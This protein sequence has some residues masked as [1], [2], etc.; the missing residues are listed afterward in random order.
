MVFVSIP[1]VYKNRP[2]TPLGGSK[3]FGTVP[4]PN[5]GIEPLSKPGTVTSPNPGIALLPNESV[6]PSVGDWF[7]GGSIDP[8]QIFLFYSLHKKMVVER[9]RSDKQP[10]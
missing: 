6:I 2:P 5:P 8:H 9:Q 3:K 4:S 7:S 10:A 1:T